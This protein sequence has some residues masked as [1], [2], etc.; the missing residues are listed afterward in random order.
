M[1]ACTSAQDGGG[2]WRD[3]TANIPSMPD[4]SPVSH[5]EPSRSEAGVAYVAFDRHMFDDFRAHIY[6]TSD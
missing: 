2:E 1:G 6:V 3:V 4:F 5:I